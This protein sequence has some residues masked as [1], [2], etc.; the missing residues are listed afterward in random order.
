MIASVDAYIG[1]FP[2]DIQD[3]LQQVRR[4]ILDAA[5]AAKEEISYGMPAYKLNGPLVYFGAAK[6]HVGFYPTASGI[7]AFRSQFE[8]AGLKYS[9]GAVQFPYDS[10][11]PEDLIRAIVAHR[12]SESAL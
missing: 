10:P 2:P 3:I 4:L 12:V 7:T 8:A 9:K 5:P 6:K 1:T 11:L